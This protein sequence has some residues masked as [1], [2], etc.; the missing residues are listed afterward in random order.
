MNQ[1]VN[2]K[3]KTK[4]PRFCS[5]SC[6]ATFTNKQVPKR[7]KVY[8]TCIEC[9]CQV[10]RRRK[11]CD[12]CLNPDMTLAELVVH[13]HHRSSA[14]AK[15]RGRARNTQ[16]FKE[17]KCCEKCGYDKHVECCHIRPISDFPETAMISE[18]NSE[19]NLMALCP[20]CHWEYDH[21]NTEG[22]TRTHKGL[23]PTV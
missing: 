9:G 15:V 20:N 23:T 16:Y 1:C 14:F 4:N 22:G 3:S 19:E 13:D 5:R 17:A 11:Y 10:D 6:S 7:K 8:S 21:A 18:I 2:C 12:D